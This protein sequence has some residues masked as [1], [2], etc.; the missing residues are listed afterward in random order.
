MDYMNLLLNSQLVYFQLAR[1]V[2]ALFAGIFLTKAVLMPATRRVLVRK[3]SSKKARH[4]ME[5]IVG[6]IGLFAT[7]TVALQVGDFGN[8]VTILGTIAAALTVA[9]GFGMRDQVANIVAGIFIHTDN[10]F[11]KGDYIK[12]NDYEGVVDEIKLRATTLNGRNTRKQVVP[13]AMLTN[14]VVKNYTKGHRTKTDIDLKLKP[15][16]L[17]EASKLL[18]Q[19][20]AEHEDVLENPALQVRYNGM[21]EDKMLTELQY[22]VEDSKDA[23]DVRSEILKEFNARAKEEGLFEEKKEE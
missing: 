17:E 3:G 14:N 12:I 2:L 15:G 20:A 23:K 13:N 5:N 7:L 6:L 9:V 21:D 10:P 22:W 16:I 1:F 19:A 18:E 4:S 11:V 8:L